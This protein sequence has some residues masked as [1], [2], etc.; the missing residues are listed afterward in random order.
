MRAFYYDA[1]IHVRLHGDKGC[2]YSR[3]NQP[4]KPV[5]TKCWAGPVLGWGG[6]PFALSRPHTSFPLSSCHLREVMRSLGSTNA[7]AGSVHLK[8]PAARASDRMLWHR[9]HHAHNA[10]GGS[11]SRSVE[12]AVYEDACQ[13]CRKAPADSMPLASL[14]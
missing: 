9:S 4:T 5:E 12:L 7:I 13:D 11:P 8:T 6:Q 3:T 1:F 14:S 2:A 10:A